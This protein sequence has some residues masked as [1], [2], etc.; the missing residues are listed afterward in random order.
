[1]HGGDVRVAFSVTPHAWEGSQ[2][3]NSVGKARVDGSWVL[4]DAPIFRVRRRLNVTMNPSV[5]FVSSF[6]ARRIVLRV[7]NEELELAAGL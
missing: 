4:F 1:M 3:R 5:S 2:A 6:K 7:S